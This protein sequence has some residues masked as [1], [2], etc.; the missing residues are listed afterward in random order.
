MNL[1]IVID[2][3]GTFVFAISGA[4]AATERRFDLFGVF[5]LGTVTAI[6]GGTLRD[7]LI[8]SAPVGWMTNEIYIYLI[9]S[10][11]PLVYLFKKHIH[12]LRKSFF[13]FDTLGIGLFTILGLQ[14]TLDAGLSPLIGVM[15]GV[16]SA[17][18]GGIIRDVLSNE[19]PLI[20]RKEIY[21]SA[22]FAGAIVYLAINIFA[23]ESVAIV[24]S[25]LTVIIIRILAV[26]KGW[27]LNIHA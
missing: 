22:C 20:F 15:M 16:T 12:K 7:L 19:V 21:A 25:I 23:P 24:V 8:G 10:S 6:G 26:K 13:L 14:K 11:V 4:L 9:I 2:Y 18:F 1:I 27:S 3:L 5:M 17:V